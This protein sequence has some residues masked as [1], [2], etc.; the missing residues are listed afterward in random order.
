[1]VINLKELNQ[2]ATQKKKY[3]RRNQMPFMTKQFSREIM[4]K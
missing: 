2:H 3:F 1:M 4:K